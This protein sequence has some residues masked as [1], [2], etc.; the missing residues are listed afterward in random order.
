MRTSCFLLCLLILSFPSCKETPH[1]LYDSPCQEG[2]YKI[3][4]SLNLRFICYNH[5]EFYNSETPDKSIPFKPHGL[6][7]STNALYP[8]NI[9]SPD[10]KWIVL[11]IGDADGFVYCKTDDLLSSLQSKQFTGQFNFEFDYDDPEISIRLL[12]NFHHWEAPATFVFYEENTD[13]DRDPKSNEI[14]KINLQTGEITSPPGAN[15]IVKP[16]LR[17]SAIYQDETEI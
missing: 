16:T 1:P 3:T 5:I 4:S 8:Y 7:T 11:K 17:K 2:K 12:S 13:T 6:I 10:E 15:P 14:Y 9:L